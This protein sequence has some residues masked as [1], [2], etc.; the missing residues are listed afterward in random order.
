MPVDNRH[1]M[2]VTTGT[3]CRGTFIENHQALARPA[4]AREMIFPAGR[5]ATM[6]R[7]GALI[8]SQMSSMPSGASTSPTART[9][10]EAR[11]MARATPERIM[12]LARKFSL[13]FRGDPDM[14]PEQAAIQARGIAEIFAL[15]PEE[16]LLAVTDL[17]R[18]LPSRQR[19][20]PS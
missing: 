16:I 1:H 18:G 7:L 2:P 12:D 10:S 5:E 6:E 8:P 4:R 17:A 14:S 13:S 19:F 11:V 20:F 9:R 3:T 15:Y